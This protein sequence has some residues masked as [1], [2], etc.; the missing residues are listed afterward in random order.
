MSLHW[1]L[2]AVFLGITLGLCILEGTRERQCHACDVVSG[3][4]TSTQPRAADAALALAGG[5]VFQGFPQKVTSLLFSCA[6][7]GKQVPDHSAC[8]WGTAPLFF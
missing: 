2:S 8:F 5:T 3:C 1:D 7:L 6:H 4:L